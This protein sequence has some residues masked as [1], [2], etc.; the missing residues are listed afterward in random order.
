MI[1][2][3]SRYNVLGLGLLVVA[4]T[5]LIGSGA[6]ADL[7]VSSQNFDIVVQYDENTGD[8]LN[9]FASGGGLSG[10]RGVLFG[11]DRNL[12]VASNGNPHGILRYDATGNFLDNF[13]Q[14]AGEL[15]GPRGIIFGPDGNLYVSSKN[16]NSINRYDGM[17]GQFIDLFVPS[18]SGGLSLPLGLV[19]GP[20]GNLY[21][22]SFNSNQVLRYDGATGNFIDVFASDI[23]TNP[24]GLTFG[25]D[26]NLYVAT[27]D[28]TP[29]SVLRF[30]STGK[31]MDVF[32][33]PDATGGLADPNGIL[34][35]PD[36]N[37]Y[38]GDQNDVAGISGGGIFRYDGTNGAF[39]DNF[40]PAQGGVIS[41]ATYLA[42]TKTDPTTLKYKP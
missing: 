38:V 16:T 35:G 2:A 31:F 36:G 20:D 5:A 24:Q 11:P 41:A 22:S 26:G 12:Y 30:D 18:D 40:V 33:S 4:L 32:V 7:F 17:T 15:N 13:V 1:R 28:P 23:L 3:R 39:I 21:V 19:F 29:A 37:L 25:P 6:R 42:F 8:F 9:V 34:F 14:S 10:P 27:G